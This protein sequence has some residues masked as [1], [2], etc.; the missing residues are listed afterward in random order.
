MYENLLLTLVEIRE[1]SVTHIISRRYQGREDYFWGPIIRTILYVLITVC[2]INC[3]T[4]MA[5]IK[6]HIVRLTEEQP[7]STYLNCPPPTRR[8]ENSGIKRMQIL[9][10]ERKE[11]KNKESKIK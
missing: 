5:V 2:C 6:T 10:N 4:S 8:K 7:N 1:N 9:R 3:A 11:S